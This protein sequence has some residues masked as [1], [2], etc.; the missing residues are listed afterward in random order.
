M[1]NNQIEA[2]I[3]FNIFFFVLNHSILNRKSP[4][5]SQDGHTVARRDQRVDLIPVRVKKSLIHHSQTSKYSSTM[6]STCQGPHMWEKRRRRR[7]WEEG[8]GRELSHFSRGGL[9]EPGDVILGNILFSAPG[10]KRSRGAAL[11]LY[12]YLQQLLLP[13]RSFTYAN[14]CSIVLLRTLFAR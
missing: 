3:C 8:G 2:K 9:L 1:R 7:R 4:Q 5:R 14:L 11:V 6:F 10:E 13:L 12:I